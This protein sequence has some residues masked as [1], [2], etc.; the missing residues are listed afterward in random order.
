MR[1]LINTLKVRRA[2]AALRERNPVA[3]DERPAP[4]GAQRY[5]QGGVHDASPA[6]RPVSA[7]H[8]LHGTGKR[9]YDWISNFRFT[10][11]EGFH[12][13]FYQLCTYFEEAQKASCFPPTAQALGLEKL[14]LGEVLSEMKSLSSRFR[15]WMAGHSQ[16]GAVM[17]VFCHRLM[18]DWACWRRT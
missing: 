12:K 16:G 8:R 11:E 10:T 9:F 7:G 4:A 2:K 18:N 5:H 3:G 14:T 13:G 15:L 17:Q 6:R 1:A